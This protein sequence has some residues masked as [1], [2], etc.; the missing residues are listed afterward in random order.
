MLEK[1]CFFLCICG[2][3]SEFKVAEDWAAEL[4][5]IKISN[6]FEGRKIESFLRWFLDFFEQPSPSRSNTLIYVSASVGQLCPA[7]KS[8]SVAQL[9]DC[10]NWGRKHR[11]RFS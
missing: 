7:H 9:H 10:L 11:W 4:K 5:Q 3:E 1:L 6:R 2:R 8:Q